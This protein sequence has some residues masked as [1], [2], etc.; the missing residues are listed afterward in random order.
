[1]AGQTALSQLDNV[2]RMAEIIA[3]GEKQ[4]RENPIISFI[5]CLVKSPLQFVNDTTQTLIEI[6]RRGLP[7]AVA[8]SP[9]AGTT[10]P[11]KEAGIVAQTNAEILAGITLSQLVNKGTPILYGEHRY[12]TGVCR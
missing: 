11:M 3:G 5:T 9:Q 8:I 4:L 1:M 7:V 12:S 2:I 10:A 6:C